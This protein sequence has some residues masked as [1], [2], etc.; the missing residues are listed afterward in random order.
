MAAGPERAIERALET[1]LTRLRPWAPRLPTVAAIVCAIGAGFAG[2]KLMWQVYD[3]LSPPPAI[4]TA[5]VP[6]LAPAADPLATAQRLAATQAFGA[7]D[8]AA[9]DAGD[10]PDSRLDLK[11]RG[12]IAAGEPRWSRAFIA[13]GNDDERAYPIGAQL[14]G[15]ALVQA[16]HPDRVVLSRSGSLETLRLPRD[17]TTGAEPGAIQTADLRGA[18]ANPSRLLDWLRPVVATESNTGRQLGYRVY[19]GRDPD[20]FT[21][22]GLLPGDLVT[23]V[24]GQPLDDPSRS[25]E[26]MRNLTGSDNITLTVERDGAQ[27]IVQIPVLQ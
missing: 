20:R 19:P 24:N 16:I 14:P 27:R 23:A 5:P 26:L 11:L 18:Q 4:A 15:G 6:T 7:P 22:L 3:A 13:S 21:K 10:A 25:M 9:I 2:A 17:A 1:A 8:A 12:V